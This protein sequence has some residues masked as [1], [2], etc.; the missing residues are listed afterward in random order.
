MFMR[1]VTAPRRA[2]ASLSGASVVLWLAGPP[3]GFGFPVFDPSN[4]GAVPAGVEL[5]PAEQQDLRNQ[6]QLA[7]GLIAGAGAGWTIL[8]RLEFQE[9]FTDNA[10]QLH[11]PREWD[12]VSIFAPGIAIAG[13][14]NRIKLNLDY[15]PSL[16]I[17]ARNG[18]QSALT[19]QLSATGLGTVIEDWAFVDVRA[20]S[21]VQS[22]TGGV[23]GLGGSNG[24]GLANI[25]TGNSG[26]GRN[27]LIQTTS[28]GI[29]PYL[30][31]QFGDVGTG[32]IGYSANM[33]RYTAL[34]GFTASPIGDAGSN[35]Q[36]MTT[37]EEIAQFTSGEILP[38]VQDV[39][40][41]HLQ[42]STSRYGQGTFA[43]GT[44]TIGTG[45]GG[46]V[47][48][49]QSR[50]ES[51]SNKVTYPIDHEFSVFASLGYEDINY[52]GAFTRSIHGLTWS[53]GTTWTPNPDSK[54]TVSY[55]R[56]DGADA[57][58]ADGTY[59]ITPRTVLGLTYSNTVG[60]RLENL[61]AGLNTSQFNAQ[62]G[63]VNG[64]TGGNAFAAGNATGIDPG[65]YRF[66]TLNVN[67][68]TLLDRDIITAGVL[69][70]KQ[71]AEGGGTPVSNSV[72]AKS[73]T[74]Q[75]TH[76]LMDDLTLNSAASYTL[77]NTSGG[78]NGGNSTVISATAALQYAVS[79]TLTTTLRYSYFDRTTA[80]TI[81]AIS[82]NLVI[83]GL[84]KHF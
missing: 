31:H 61:Q 1:I 38:F 47:V 44:G 8:P 11:A 42:Q 29:S 14:T 39:V 13:N 21:G 73:L 62:G 25:S 26:L 57:F 51:I 50:R 72:D 60:T 10:L 16:A 48:T 33:S 37:Q 63:L 69:W 58:S 81:L 46:G 40:D 15:S 75:W 20:I 28:F 54:I 84:T 70:S 82:Q 30:L 4:L 34:N 22:R 35:G 5:A 41:V 2:A 83:L 43:T 76:Q 65:I 23:G 9:M 19:H 64:R 49:S 53:V 59:S 80:T 3:D 68:R 56:H 78:F 71:T 24:N 67:V 17:Y 18:S 12:L 45:T 55:G 79:D 32:K 66:S 7:N 27:N 52:T 36:S 74:V 77:Q 6:L